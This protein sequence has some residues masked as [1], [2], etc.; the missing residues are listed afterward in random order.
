MLIG[1]TGEAGSGKDEA[2]KAAMLL[3]RG[4][5]KVDYLSFADPLKRAAASLFDESLDKFINNKQDISPV[6]G[7]SYRSL[8]QK[9]GTD[10]ARDMVHPDFWVKRAEVA[11]QTLCRMEVEVILVCDVRFDNEAKFITDRG[12]VVLCI[13]RNS[14]YLEGGEAQHKSEG[15]V[16]QKYITRYIKNNKGIPALQESI[17][18]ALDSMANNTK[19]YNP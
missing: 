1:F 4:D 17:K 12:G 10:F 15:G 7:I 16:S 9:L 19:I 3:L 14:K 11:Y 18:N 8:L 13:T 6:W 5:Y 2:G